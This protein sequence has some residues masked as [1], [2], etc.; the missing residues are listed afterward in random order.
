MRALSGVPVA[1]GSRP[2]PV[3]AQKD[4]RWESARRQAL[5]CF[6]KPGQTLQWQ[7]HEKQTGL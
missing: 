3:I 1:T 2:G 7:K 5:F 6:C 4:F